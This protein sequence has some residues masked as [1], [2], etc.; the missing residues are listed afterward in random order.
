MNE[1]PHRPP[2]SSRD[3]NR[4]PQTQRPPGW[5]QRPRKPELIKVTDRVYCSTGYAISNVLYVITD[6]SVVVIDTTESPRAARASFDDFRKVCQSPVSYIIYTHYHGDHVQG[7]KVFHMAETQVIAQ[8]RMLEERE[9]MAEL[10]PYK[11]RIDA[12][13]FGAA[14]DARNRGISLESDRKTGGRPREITAQSKFTDAGYIPP[15]VTFDEEYRFEEGGVRF[16]LYHTE[17]ETFGHLMVWLPEERA[18]FPGDLFYGAFPMLSNPMKPDRP[19]LAWAQSLD[20]MR[21]LRPRHLVPSHSRPRQG[22]PE[23]DEAL[24]NYAKAIRHVHDETVRLI[25]L[26]LSQEE[27]RRRVK[28]PEELSRLPYLQQ[29]Y[30]KVE[31]AVNGI[32]RQYTGWYDLNPTNL[33]PAPRA[34]RDRALLEACGGPETLVRRAHQ[35]LRKGQNQLVLEL[36]DIVL[37]ARPQNRAAQEIRVKAL[38]RLGTLA[39]NGVEQNIYRTAAVSLRTRGRTHTGPLAD[40]ALPPQ[41]SRERTPEP[42]LDSVPPNRVASLSVNAQTANG[43]SVHTGVVSKVA[44]QE[45]NKRV[46]LGT[47]SSPLFLLAPPRSFTSVISAM[48]GQHPQMYGLPEMHL[49]GAETI[50]EWWRYF[51]GAKSLRKAGTLRAVAQLY[52]GKQTEHSIKLAR[53]WLRRR[54]HL[55]TGLLFQR[56]AERV[57][58]RILVDKSTSTVYRLESMQRTYD[59]FPHARY[60]HLVRHPRGHGES[61]MKFINEREKIGL[62]PSRHWMLRLASLRDRSQRQDTQRIDGDLDPQYGWYRLNMTICKFLESVPEEQKLR[63]R[64]EDLLTDPGRVLREIA[65]WMGVRTDD[66]AIEEM[67]HPERSP[68]ACFGPPGARFGNDRFFLENPALRPSRADCHS[69]KGPL[70]W[71]RDG[72]GF[73]PKVKQL[74]RE[75]GYD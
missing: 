51:S 66:E 53:R 28:L 41:P 46:F 57:D 16:E 54:S 39:K 64:S 33:R 56:L 49:F 14:L 25:N 22:A 58:P 48:L 24:A 37:S 69:L 2:R 50:G 73:L 43:G 9:R 8:K 36:T 44:V 12:L 4:T 18:L 70:I 68:Y 55:T 3:N 75:F 61:V 6:R 35:A 67:K 7:A 72:K 31:W 1:T 34:M 45:D 13:Q 26:G 23:I 10:L 21:A 63:V 52:F 29:G 11:S 65:T 59:V 15:D 47:T 30:G 40:F 60:I 62:L 38:N 71:R 5:R 20:R 42:D 19:V 74:A 32:F 17:G 27:I